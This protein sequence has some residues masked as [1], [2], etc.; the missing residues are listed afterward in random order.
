MAKGD[1]PEKFALRSYLENKRQLTKQSEMLGRFLLWRPER[2]KT[3]SRCWWW[4]ER[5]FFENLSFVN[6]AGWGLGEIS[7]A[8]SC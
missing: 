4:K 7:R 3:G 1:L 6:G 8:N 2:E 5:D